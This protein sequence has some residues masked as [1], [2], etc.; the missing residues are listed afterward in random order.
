MTDT[1]AIADLSAERDRALATGD[2]DLLTQLLA[3]DLVHV[4]AT[5]RIDGKTAYLEL[6]RE[7]LEFPVVE[8][9]EAQVRRY[10]FTAILTGKLRQVVR[11]K[12][13]GAEQQ[14]IS[15]MTQVWALD[16]DQWRMVSFQ[17]TP[18]G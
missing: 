18:A 3:D 8:T 16:D 12:A 1:D 6:V 5:G 7:R 15:A 4:H 14:T 17:A 2:I 13:T 11:I 10:G 9:S